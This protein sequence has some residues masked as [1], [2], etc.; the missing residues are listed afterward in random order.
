MLHDIL[1]KIIE[2]YNPKIYDV[3]LPCPPKFGGGTG[4]GA[5]GSE[6]CGWRDGPFGGGWICY[7][8]GRGEGSGRG[9]GSHTGD[10]DY[11]GGG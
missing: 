5:M 2:P 4:A 6:I 3:S 9:S 7:T 1:K 10:G 8:F 11:V